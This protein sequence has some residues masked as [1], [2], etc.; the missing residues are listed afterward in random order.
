MRNILD[1]CSSLTNLAD[2]AGME[3]KNIE[4]M[5]FCQY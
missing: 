2:F 4:N 1:G 5:S 3:N